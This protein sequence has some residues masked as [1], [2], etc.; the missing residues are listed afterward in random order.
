M[1]YTTLPD[2]ARRLRGRLEINLDEELPVATIPG[3]G[4]AAS[5][6]VVDP[7]LVVQVAEEKEAY[8]DLVLGQIYVIPLVLTSEVTS[9]IMKDMT[10]C[11]VISSLIQVHFEGNNPIVPAADISGAS[12]DLS[13]QAHYMLAALTA[14]HNIFIPTMPAPQNSMVNVP[15]QHALRLPGEKLLS[16][17]DRPDTVTRNYT[18]IAPMMG[19]TKHRDSY[20]SEDSNPRFDTH[21]TRGVEWLDLE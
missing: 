9:R 17:T 2:I 10:E 19:K 20:F 11:L 18:Y 5:G 4:Q 14:G 16:A 15:E 6:Q 3:Y 21:R 1:K 12:T 7:E 8:L 13:R